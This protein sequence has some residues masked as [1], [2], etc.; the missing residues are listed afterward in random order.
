MR[1]LALLLVTALS[2]A[3][4]ATDGRSLDGWDG[5]PDHWK[6]TDGTIVGT[7]DGS[8][9]FNTFLVSQMKFKDFELSFKVRLKGGKGNS[10]VQIRSEVSD[11]KR[12]A[13]R[14]PQADIG[15]KYWGSLYG[16]QSG[17]MMQQCD[18]DKV[19]PTLKP[20]DFNDYFVRVVGKKVTIKVNGVT[21]VDAEF[22][23]LPPEGVIA[24]QIHQGPPMEVTLREIKFKE[25]K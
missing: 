17:G 2:G 10:G 14:G 5:L 4:P 16:E 7:S 25:L 8:L 11:R 15:D 18:F 9:K 13:V 12:L 3:Q 6:A 24:F 21:T 1:H 19:R 23:K 20:D 22:E